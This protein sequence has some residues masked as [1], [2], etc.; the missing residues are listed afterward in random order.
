MHFLC[1]DHPLFLRLDERTF[2]R[3]VVKLHDRGE[4]AL[5][6]TETAV[7]DCAVACASQ[8]LAHELGADDRSRVSVPEQLDNERR[9]NRSRVLIRLFEVTLVASALRIDRSVDVRQPESKDTT[10]LNTRLSSVK[11]GEIA[12]RH[13]WKG[14]H[15]TYVVYSLMW[16]STCATTPSAENLIVSQNQ[17][18]L[19]SSWK[20]RRE[21]LQCDDNVA[22]FVGTPN[23]SWVSQ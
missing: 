11:P 23:S 2:D 18:R 21:E 20:H 9:A 6:L 12:E 5:R 10:G 4:A 1:R 22:S 13:F 17:G 8:D 14:V 16:S 7:P 19:T 3:T 15:R